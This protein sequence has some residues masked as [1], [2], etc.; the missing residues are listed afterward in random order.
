[1][2]LTT[3]ANA[4]GPVPVIMELAFSQDFM[5]ALAR[6]IPEMI[7]GGPGNT[8]S[9]LAAAGAGRGMGIRDAVCRR[10]TRPTMARD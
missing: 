9:E 10:A 1:M 7:P 4:A 5:E 2:M 8:G 3:P 6:S